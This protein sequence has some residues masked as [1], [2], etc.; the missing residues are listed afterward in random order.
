MTEEGWLQCVEPTLIMAESLPTPLYQ[1][2]HRKVRLFLAACCRRL[3]PLL[4][5]ERSKEAIATVERF[6]DGLAD[7]K[8][9]ERARHAAHAA[10][11][12]IAGMPFS[13]EQAALRLAADTVAHLTRKSM[14]MGDTARAAVDAVA[15]AAAQ[16][17]AQRGIA[18]KARADAEVAESRAQAALCRHISGN[19][20]RFYS[21]P[22]YW[23]SV[24]V[25]LAEALYEQQDV[26]FALADA[27]EEAG[28]AE[29]AEHFR[30][31][32][33]HPKGCWAMD[34]VLG[35]S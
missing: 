4:A 9:L 17:G 33:E 7:K 28:H 32:K 35:K 25:Q 13:S 34:L 24:I 15:E 3:W 19:P 6:A 22:L 18:A 31:E 5:D 1:R 23:P 12:T 26:A 27:L 30:E 21:T 10:A 20:F 11:R 16:A 14:S 2:S 8:D 29:L